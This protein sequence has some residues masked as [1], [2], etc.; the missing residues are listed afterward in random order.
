MVVYF[1]VFA[2]GEELVMVC[3]WRSEENLQDSVLSSTMWVPSI[4]FRLSS[5]ALSNIT[6]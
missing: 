5:L 4:E 2:G 1:C 3:M 6:Y